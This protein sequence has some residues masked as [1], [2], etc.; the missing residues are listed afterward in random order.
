MS[1][2]NY[3][4]RLSTENEQIVCNPT[5]LTYHFDLYRSINLI[6]FFF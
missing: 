1:Q 3:L 5:I 6:L 4:M 2:L